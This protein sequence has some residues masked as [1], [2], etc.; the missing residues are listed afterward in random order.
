MPTFIATAK[1]ASPLK[2]SIRFGVTTVLDMHS[3]P[4]KVA[5]LKEV[6][7]KENSVAD[8]KS[9]CHAATIENGWPVPIVLALGM[10]P[11]VELTLCIF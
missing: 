4:D 7:K 9:A 3:Q 6:A 11:E 8:F 5:M 2:Q 1:D 10:S